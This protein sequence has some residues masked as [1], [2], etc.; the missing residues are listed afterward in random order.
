MKDRKIIDREPVALPVLP[1]ID[2][3]RETRTVAWSTA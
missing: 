2:D 3:Q 1:G